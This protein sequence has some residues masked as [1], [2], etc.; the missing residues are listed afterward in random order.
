MAC[1]LKPNLDPEL[2]IVARGGMV[3]TDHGASIEG[4]RA[5]VI[6]ASPA[7]LA[8]AARA[9]D[10]PCSSGA[11]GA[12]P[13]HIRNKEA[14]AHAGGGTR[15]VGQ[16]TALATTP[17]ATTSAGCPRAAGPAQGDVQRE[18]AAIDRGDG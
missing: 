11:A 10:G 9:A 12:A 13:R 6:D 3:A 8:C 2:I 17:C 14:I 1:C 4:E 18:G 5:E 16:A 7:A 15:G